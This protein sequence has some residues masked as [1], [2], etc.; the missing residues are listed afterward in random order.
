MRIRTLQGPRFGSSNSSCTGAVADDVVVAGAHDV[1]A[2][3]AVSRIPYR[4]ANQHCRQGASS[5]LPVR[6]DRGVM[7]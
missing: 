1:V 5:N 2:S 3:A 7:A 4:S 6:L